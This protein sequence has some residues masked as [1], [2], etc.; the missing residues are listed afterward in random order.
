MFFNYSKLIGQQFCS[1]ENRI[2]WE[3]I[4]GWEDE[5]G[6]NCRFQP[7]DP[8][9]FAAS[10]NRPIRHI[11]ARRGEPMAKPRCPGCDGGRVFPGLSV[12]ARGER[13]L[14]IFGRN[15]APRTV[16]RPDSPL[17]QAWGND[18]E[19]QFSLAS[20]HFPLSP[21]RMGYGADAVR[22]HDAP[23]LRGAWVR[24][25]GHRHHRP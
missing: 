22:T 12:G 20:W 14:N 4:S 17:P 3:K 18:P 15:V 7:R 19:I 2:R 11:F 8:A 23:C 5:L 1:L 10:D 25:A 6:R 21:H 13:G 16:E 9:V 24:T